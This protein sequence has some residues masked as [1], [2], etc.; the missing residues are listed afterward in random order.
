MWS[1][2]IQE[3]RNVEKKEKIPVVCLLDNKHLNMDKRVQIINMDW[4]KDFEKI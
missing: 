4:Q 1:L 3:E 2:S